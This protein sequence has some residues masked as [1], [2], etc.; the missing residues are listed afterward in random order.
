M[1]S[2][3]NSGF[4][5]TLA[6]LLFILNYK[7]IKGASNKCEGCTYNSLNNK[8]TKNSDSV[9]CSSDCRPHFYSGDC[10]DCTQ[11]FNNNPLKLYSIINE[12]CDYNRGDLIISETNEFVSNTEFEEKTKDNEIYIFGEFIYKSCPDNSNSLFEDDIHKC[13]CD[14]NLKKKV[15]PDMIFGKSLFRCAYTCPYAYYFYY[16]DYKSHICLDMT[17]ENSYKNIRTDNLVVNNCES[18]QK[19]Y[20]EKGEGDYKYCLSVCPAS[21]PFYTNTENLQKDIKCL[22]KCPDNFFYDLNTKECIQNCANYQSWIDIK[23]KTFICVKPSN[24]VSNTDVDCPD[25]FPYKYK[26]SCLRNCSDTNDDFF[27]STKSHFGTENLKQQTYSLI[28]SSRKMCVKICDDDEYTIYGKKYHEDLTFTCVSNCTKTSRKYIKD[29]ECVEKCS[30]GKEFHNYGQFE[31]VN[32]CTDSEFKYKSDLDKTCYKDCSKLSP[33]FYYDKNTKVCVNKCENQKFIYKK[34]NGGSGD[35]SYSLYCLESC[36]TPIKIGETTVTINFVHRYN[37]NICIENCEVNS[38]IS[39]YY[40]ITDDDTCYQSCDEVNQYKYKDQYNAGNKHYKFEYGSNCYTDTTTSSGESFANELHYTMKSGIIKY[41]STTE[42]DLEFCSKAG[43]YYIYRSGTSKEC[44]NCDGYKIPYSLKSDDG[45]IE[46]LGECLSE[47]NAT[48]PYYNTDDKLCQNFCNHKI[49]ISVNGDGSSL[50]LGTSTKGNCMTECP[51]DFKYE[52]SNGT[53]CYNKCPNTEQYFYKIGDGKY[54]CIKDCTIISKFYIDG[55]TNRECLDKCGSQN[56]GSSD[57]YTG[58]SISSYIYYIPGNIDNKCLTTCKDQSNY[59]FSLQGSVND[60]QP[61]LKECPLRYQYYDDNDKICLSRCPKYFE[62]DTKQCIDKCPSSDTSNNKYIINENECSNKCTQNATF[63]VK[64]NNNGQPEKKCDIK[65]DS[66]HHLYYEVDFDG[67]KAYQ[68]TNDCSENENVGSNKLELEYGNKCV[69]ECPEETFKDDKKCILKCPNLFKRTLPTPPDEKTK[70]DCIED[71]DKYISSTKECVEQCPREENFVNDNTCQNYCDGVYIKY[72]IGNDKFGYYDIYQCE[73]S[74][75]STYPYTLDGTKEC[76]SQCTEDKPYLLGKVC[77]AICLKDQIKPFSATKGAKKECAEKCSTNSGDPKYNGDDKICV[78]SC[79]IFEHKKYHNEKENDYACVSHCDLK[80]ENRFTYYDDRNDKYYCL[81]RCDYLSETNHDLTEKIFY[82]TDD[83]ICNNTCNDRNIFLI[84]DQHICTNK[85]PDNLVA[86]PTLTANDQSISQYKCE[87]TC[88]QGTYYYENERICG[89]CQPSHYI[90]QGTQKCIEFC[91]QIISQKNYYSYEKTEDSNIIKNNTCVTECPEDKP[92]VDYNNHC[93]VQCTPEYKFYKPS[94]KKCMD[95]CPNNTLTN[96]DKCVEKCPKDKV[97]DSIAKVCLDDCFYSQRN[98]IYYYE[99]ERVCLQEC[100]PGDFIYIDGNNYK[101]MSNCSNINEGLNKQL[102]IDGNKCVETCSDIR[103][104]FVNQTA[105][106]EVNISKYCL[107][108]CP[109]GFEFYKYDNF[110]CSGICYDYYI[111]NKDPN[112]IGKVCVKECNN[113]YPYILIHNNTH[114]ECVEFC[115][116]GKMFYEEEDNGKKTCYEKCPPSSPFHKKGVFKCQKECES[117]IANKKTMECVT[118]CELNQFWAEETQNSKTTKMCYDNCNQ[119]NYAQFSTFEKK[120][121]KQ[122]NETN[123]FLQGN[124]DTHECECRGLYYI[125]DKGIKQCLDPK[126]KLCT[127]TNSDYTI[128]V[129]GT[130]QCTKIC[131]GVLSVDGDVCY[132]GSADSIKCPENSMLG[133]F[134]GDIKCECQYGF[135]TNLK[136]KKVCLDKTLKCPDYKYFNTQTRECVQTCGDLYLVDGKCYSYCPTGMIPSDGTPRTCTCVYNFYKTDEDKYVCLQEYDQCPF[137]YPYLIVEKKECVKECSKE[138]PI[139]YDMKCRSNCEENYHRIKD[140]NNPDKYICVCDNIW[141]YELDKSICDVN[142]HDKTC[143]KLNMGLNYTVVKTKQCVSS[144]KGDY[145]YFFNKKCYYNCSEEDLVKDPN[146]NEC[147]CKGKWRLNENNEIECIAQNCDDN[148]NLLTETNQCIPKTSD[149]SFDKPLF[150]NN[151]CYKECPSN[152]VEDS[153]KGNTCKCRFNWFIRN[154]NLIECM[155]E[156]VEC[157]YDSHPYLIYQTKQCAKTIEDCADKYIFNFVCYDKCPDN[158][159]KSAD[160]KNCECDSNAGYWAKGKD[161]HG[162]DI[163]ECGISSCD[164]KFTD[165]KKYDND[166][167]ECVSNCEIPKYLYLDIC[168][169]SCPSLTEPVIN[170]YNCKLRNDID[171]PDLKVLL[172]NVEDKINEINENIPK[173]GIVINNEENEATVQVYRLEDDEK[174]NKEALLRSNLAYVDISECIAKIRK[175]NNMKEGEQVIMVKLDL[176]SKSK[177]LIVNPV[178]YEF[179]SSITGALLDA[180]VCERNEVVVS[181]PLTYL[182]KNRKKLR[183]LDD[184]EMIEIAEKFERGKLLYQKDNFIDSF[185]YN[186][187]I[188]SDICYPI[189]VDGKDLTLEN[190]I[191]YFYPNYSFCESSCLYDYTDF[192]NERIF[193][194]CSIKLK[195]DVDRPQG[196]KLSEYNKEET[197]SNQMGPTNLPA[198]TCLSKVKISGNPAFIICLIFFIVQLG[199]LFIII[200]KGLS[201]LITNINKKLYKEED[202]NESNVDEDFKMNIKKNKEIDNGKTSERKL[203]NPP[204]KNNYV[205]S[206]NIVKAKNP[207]GSLK[208]RKIYEEKNKFD[209]LSDENKSEEYYNYLKKNEIDT[210]KGFFTS[211]KKEEK[212]LRE[213]FSVSMTKDKFDIVV[214]ILTSIFDKIY[215]S[216]VLLFSSKYQITS[217][218][219]SLYLLCHLLLLTLCALFFD[220]KTISK[221][222]EKE[223]YPNLGYYILYGFL[224]NLIVWAIFKLFYCLIDNSNNIRKLFKKHAS[225]N[226]LKKMAKLNKLISGIKKD[227][228]IYLVIEFVLIVLC[229]LYLIAFCG[230]YTGTKSKLFLSY[231]F[232]LVTIVIIKIIYGFILGI[233]RKISLFAEKSGLYN[234]VLIFNKYIS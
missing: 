197:D 30:G 115:P 72:G 61:C 10:Y 180:S 116:E 50:S 157:P 77:V 35:D 102:Y 113:I 181:Y 24:G 58:V 124:L 212:Y 12:K 67:V 49:I 208:I 46:K 193:C 70:Y 96:G 145:Q 92:F 159:I 163:L 158:S 88:K 53:H 103:K 202:L 110:E 74:C 123:K 126:I 18:D 218:M 194:N 229:S 131:F 62:S 100:R 99:S 93:S 36:K 127:E 76:V 160:D 129:N 175:N 144:C 135:Y 219:F 41:R 209:A 101:C 16:P 222:F 171:N 196:V 165:K 44:K 64:I 174:K 139:L 40:H 59:Q 1:K 190:R 199:L 146:S 223:N 167:K 210:D 138:Y 29:N 52:S 117:G 26:T 84:P 104:F 20:I 226:N 230:V 148:E 75:N 178:E 73:T 55:G 125:N 185:N 21:F 162:R 118:D 90:I 86:N 134:D 71:C 132:W 168:Y 23:T 43:F 217:L 150:W 205:D 140:P 66:D 182:F 128:Q 25:E 98:Y 143:K 65:C 179:R 56:Q 109:I 2:Y 7:S 147:K 68:C 97:E 63:I 186:S 120:C 69:E 201:S 220:I 216:K 106:G 80:S 34:N 111:R 130:N 60:P 9:I 28:T 191:S 51:S 173:G 215:L 85:C 22:E 198:F 122:C 232:A 54:K 183:L 11:I 192:M 133:I 151:L 224:G 4:Y 45:S 207:K 83:Y 39:L 233:L 169:S 211:V 187:T 31:C 81:N 206:K 121:V 119:T 221:I 14:I 227:I 8:C 166:T 19:Y 176:K 228:V 105:Y 177:K 3:K 214:V 42:S 137:E 225:S 57:I 5:I 154:D 136:G 82:S 27:L 17:K 38:E 142:N 32:D 203:N 170:E 15:Y 87:Y 156:G 33:I 234:V 94:E 200:F 189:E 6:I 195:L 13:I 172:K 78:D 107:T 37:D 47:C 108:D 149:C 213:N 114:K 188:Y 231:A 112:V 184:E 152:T 153:I 204:K 95:K 79:N 161:T 141:Y 164:K 91:D 89:E 155:E 48:F